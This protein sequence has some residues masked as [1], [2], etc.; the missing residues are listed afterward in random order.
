M[1][2]WQRILL[3]HNNSVHSIFLKLNKMLINDYRREKDI[4]KGVQKTITM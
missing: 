2:A 4:G 1:Q 3:L